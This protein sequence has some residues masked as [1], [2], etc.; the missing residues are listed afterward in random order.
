MLDREPEAVADT[1]KGKQRENAASD[2]IKARSIAVMAGDSGTD[3]P[4]AGPGAVGGE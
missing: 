4:G 1:G 2:D 3:E